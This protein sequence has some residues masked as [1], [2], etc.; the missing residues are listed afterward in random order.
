MFK[1]TIL[2]FLIFFGLIGLLVWKK[3]PHKRGQISDP[4]PWH[5]ASNYPVRGLDLSHHNGKIMY[6]GLD[7]LDF[8]FLKAS[9]G[10]TLI[11]R[12]FENHYK[13]F[14]EK[15]IAL[16]VYH[17]FRFDS[18]G[19][20]QATHF[21][22]RIKGYTFHVPLIVDVEQDKNPKIDRNKVIDRLRNFIHHIQKKTGQKPII[23][24]NGDEYSNFVQNEFDDQT[25][26]L[27]TTNTWRPAMMDCTFWQFNIDADLMEITHRV[28]LNVFRGSREEWNKYLNVNKPYTIQ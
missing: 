15:G 12:D 17:F 20:E 25:L 11:D 8:V 23:Y 18:E 19:E 27:S 2:I 3:F 7:S 4:N 13:G 9:E 26:W 5:L 24:T 14:K 6:E 21:L 22:N 1:L 10:T 16:G 28:D